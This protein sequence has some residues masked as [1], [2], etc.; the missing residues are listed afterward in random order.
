MC[1]AGSLYGAGADTSVAGINKF[2]MAMALYPEV[3]EKARKELDSVCEGRV[4]KFPLSLAH[5]HDGF[6]KAAYV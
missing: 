1:S 6:R 3:Q 4:H 5:L 2:I